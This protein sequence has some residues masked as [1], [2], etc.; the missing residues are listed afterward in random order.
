MSS[1]DSS[2]NFN[3][4]NSY[5]IGLH[6]RYAVDTAALESFKGK[7]H[8]GD[9]TDTQAIS[10]H[11]KILDYVPKPDAF[12][13]LFKVDWKRRWAYFDT[14]ANF[15]NQRV[16]FFK[17]MDSV[18][19]DEADIRRVSAIDVSHQDQQEQLQRS[20]E[21]EILEKICELKVELREDY[22]HIMGCVLRYVKG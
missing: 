7:Y 1:I 9:F 6:S 4:D 11:A 15:D 2:N 20:K 13:L 21:K 14:P 16:F 3:L 17:S 12:A 22:N 10:D 18:E 19:K 8:I 5:N